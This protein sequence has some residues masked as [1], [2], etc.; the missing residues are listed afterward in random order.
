M[1]QLIKKAKTIRWLGIATIVILPIAIILV[2]IGAILALYLFEIGMVL[3]WIGVGLCIAVSPICLTS[4]IKVLAT[5]WE[6]E[7]LENDKITWGL[8]D[9]LIIPGIASIVFSS[10]AIKLLT[11]H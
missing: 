8:L 11:I 2:V 3:L 9:L 4:S 1:E 5:N 10:K 6:N 7:Q